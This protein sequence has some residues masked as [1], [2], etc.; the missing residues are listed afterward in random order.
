MAV[1]CHR[2]AAKEWSGTFKELE[3]KRAKIKR[4]INHHVSE[5]KKIDKHESLGEERAKRAEQAIDSHSCVVYE[6]F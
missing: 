4:L 3:E 2:I 5:H 6:R 1:K